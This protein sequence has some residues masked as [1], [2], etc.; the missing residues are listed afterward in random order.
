MFAGSRLPDKAFREQVEAECAGGEVWE[1]VAENRQALEP[2]QRRR[3]RVFWQGRNIRRKFED[4]TTWTMR[5]RPL[6]T[7]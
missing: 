5:G 2:T 6:Q 1:A 7:S 4:R 3:S